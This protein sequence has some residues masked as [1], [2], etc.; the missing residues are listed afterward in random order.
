M[1]EF[2]KKKECPVKVTLRTCRAHILTQYYLTYIH[3]HYTEPDID[4]LTNLKEYGN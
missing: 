3:D 1:I 2:G 4:L